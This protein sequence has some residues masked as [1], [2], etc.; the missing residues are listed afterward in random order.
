MKSY[1]QLLII[2][3]LLGMCYVTIEGIWRIPSGGFVNIWMLVVGGLAGLVVGSI[4][5]IPK[6]Y[7]LTVTTQ[8]FIGAI[9]TTIIE[10]ISG[11][12]LNKIFD[13]GIWDYSELPFNIMGQICLPFSIIWFFMMPLAIWLEDN[14]RY[15]LWDCGWSYSLKKIYIE[16]FTGK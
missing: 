11:I 12:I 13:L 7:N 14:I 2:W 9:S 1:K 6:F 10:F 5:Q 8:A 15:K 16:F 3:L 4:N